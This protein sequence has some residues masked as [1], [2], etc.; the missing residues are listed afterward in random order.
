MV[1]RGD[2]WCGMM[3]MLRTILVLTACGGSVLAGDLE[4]TNLIPEKGLDGWVKRGGDAP[5]VVEDG[6]IVGD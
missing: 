2:V 6:C 5:F 3:K 4:W 1:G